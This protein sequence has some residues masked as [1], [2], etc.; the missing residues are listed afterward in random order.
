MNNLSQCLAETTAFIRSKTHVVPYI[1]YLTGTGLGDSAESMTVDTA[2]EYRNIPHFPISTVQSHKGRLLIGRLVDCPLIVLQ[3]RFHLYEGYS[4]KEVT[5]PVRLMQQLGVKILILSNAAGGLNPSFSP[6]DIMLISDHINLTLTN[7]LI[8]PNDDDLGVRFPDMSRA[9]NLELI[10]TAED[11]ARAAG[12]RLQ[13][14][15]YVGLIGPALETPAEVEFL[16]TIGAEAVGFSTVQ[17]VIAAVHG[18]LRVMGLSVITN[19]HNPVDPVPASVEEIIAVAQKAAPSLGTI[20]RGVAG[21]I[22][23]TEIR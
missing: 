12:I 7:P 2:I 22:Y 23:E 14:G 5:Y 1:G 10:S 21:K 20:L 16:E 6:G 18:G 8:G 9:Y 17:E 3:G 4:P 13:K 19:V 11:A 15:I